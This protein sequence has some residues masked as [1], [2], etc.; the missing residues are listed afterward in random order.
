MREARKTHT[1]HRLSATAALLSTVLLVAAC[2][3]TP[4]APTASL[5]AAKVAI[6]NAERANAGR[7]AGAELGT[8]RQKLALADDAVNKENMTL[9][10]R[11]ADE[12]RVE[13]DLAY[14]RTEAAKAAAVNVEMGRGADALVEEMQRAGDQQRE[15]SAGDP[16]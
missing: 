5:D 6:A 2:A 14:A 1:G 13:A 10:A 11:L 4:V 3:S 7:F 16:R 9:A 8:A 12:A 15:R